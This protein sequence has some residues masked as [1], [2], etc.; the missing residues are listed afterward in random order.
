LFSTAPVNESIL[1][2]ANHFLPESL[3]DAP[4]W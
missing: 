2:K 4:K 3:S 1:E